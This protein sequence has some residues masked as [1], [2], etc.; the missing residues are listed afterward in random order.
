MR[1][2]YWRTAAAMMICTLA[3]CAFCS[4]ALA[5][6]SSTTQVADEAELTAALAATGVRYIAFNAD[7]TTGSVTIPADRTVVV[8]GH[9][10]N[11]GNGTV[12]GAVDVSAAGA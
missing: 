9:T 11:I 7:I 1:L 12:T 3:V 4:A 8:G 2:L 5:D 6:G 10:W